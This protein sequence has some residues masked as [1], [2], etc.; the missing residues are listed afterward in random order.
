MHLKKQVVEN[1]KEGISRDDTKTAQAP[2]F[3]VIAIAFSITERSQTYT[4]SS[5]PSWF[6]EKKH[7]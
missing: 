2:T 3:H 1:S 7:I 4:I 5:F 6:G